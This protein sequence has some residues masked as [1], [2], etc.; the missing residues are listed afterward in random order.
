M[1]TY[2]V[3]KIETYY[4]EAS[5]ETEAQNRVSELDNSSAHKVELEI[6]L[7]E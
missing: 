2:K 1:S 3:V 6:D 5:D 7:H 4:I